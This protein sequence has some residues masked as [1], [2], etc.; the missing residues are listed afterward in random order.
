M[1]GS[2]AAAVF[3]GH[4]SGRDV[5][6]NTD[7]NRGILL[8]RKISCQ[9]MSEMID[10]FERAMY[11]A[12]K[13]LLKKKRADLVIDRGNIAGEEQP[14]YFTGHWTT[15]S[16]ANNGEPRFVFSIANTKVLR[17]S[18]GL[19]GGGPRSPDYL[20]FPNE[21]FLEM[22]WDKKQ[23]LID[24]TLGSDWRSL[25][26]AIKPS[27]EDFGVVLPDLRGIL[28]EC[29]HAGAFL[30]I[31]L[32]QA[33][34]KN[35]TGEV[36]RGQPEYLLWCFIAFLRRQ[37]V[38]LLPLPS[39][40]VQFWASVHTRYDNEVIFSEAQNN[41][42]I[43]LWG[44]TEKYEEPNRLRIMRIAQTLFL[45]ADIR[46]TG[47]ISP[48]AF[49]TVM[50]TILGGAGASPTYRARV[51][52]LARSTYDFFAVFWNDSE[53]LVQP[54]TYAGAAFRHNTPR[55]KA[56]INSSKRR[57]DPF[58]FAG[59][60][61]D[62]WH[63]GHPIAGYTPKDVVRAWAAVL[64]DTFPHLKV[65]DPTRFRAAGVHWLAYI[66]SLE[67]PPTQIEDLVRSRHIND[68]VSRSE[69]T[70]RRWLVDK[71]ESPNTRNDVLAAVAQ[72]FD[73][74]LRAHG[75]DLR[76][77]IQFDLDRFLAPQQRGKTPRTPLSPEM[78]LFLKDFN[79]QGD[80]AFSRSLEPMSWTAEKVLHLRH[81]RRV[82][83]PEDGEQKIMWW[84][85]LA[86][87][88]DLMLTI[89]LRG[90]QAR[91]LDTGE[92]DE[93]ITDPHTLE[94]RL[95]LLP[96]A[97]KG[98]QMGVFTSFS[99]GVE[100][101]ERLLGLRI[102]TNKQA[103]ECDG[104]YGI[105]WCPDDLRDSLSML[106]AWQRYYNPLASLVRAERD[107][108]VN[109]LRNEEV[110]ALI[111]LICPLFRDP[112]SE[113]GAL[114]PTYQQ[115]QTYWNLLC[116][117]AED[118]LH[119]TRKTS[120]RLTRDRIRGGESS[121]SGLQERVAL[122]DLHT[123]RVS[124]ITAL[125]ES[126]L[127]PHLVQE[128]VG[129]AAIVMTLYYQ[130][131]HPGQ[132]NRALADA[133]ESRVLSLDRIPEVLDNLAT[134]ESFL[135]NNRAPEDSVG[136]EMLRSA[137]GN[138]SYQ[139][140][141]HGI[142]P[143]G[144]CRTGGVYQQSM[145]EHAAVP[146]AGACALCR[147]RITGP[148]FL[149]GL[150]VNAN[151]IMAELHGK[152]QEIA[153]LNDEIRARRRDE[154]SVMAF[155]ARYELLHRELEDLWLEWASEHQYVE[156]SAKLLTDYLK[157]QV[158]DGRNLPVLVA[159]GAIAQMSVKSE[160]RHPFHLSQ[161]LAEASAFVPSE[162]HIAAIGMRDVFLNELLVNN[163]IDP[164]LLRLNADTRLH[165][166]NMLGRL[167]SEMVPD[168]DLQAVHDGL[169]PVSTFIGLQEAIRELA[170]AEPVA[171]NSLG[172]TWPRTGAGIL[173]TEE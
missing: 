49:I 83:D 106:L 127:P 22:S 23:S 147:Y 151:K 46:T 77:P 142:C 73:I 110:T 118:H 51:L 140:L 68:L 166:G 32:D 59:V 132:V 7:M 92:G 124:G 101:N 53:E 113:N 138:G 167:L 111:P 131:L 116:V 102:T 164:F 72:M 108:W 99:K 74:H 37:G 136:H 170:M 41:A 54:I 43:R 159:D 71:L 173:E 48:D 162:R 169:L 158:Q 100:T 10:E 128:I 55:V 88:L 94:E 75:I 2:D 90:F 26:A 114:P 66:N 15:G 31:L 156:D 56:A 47:D 144:D 105:P 93:F 30:K 123:L 112:G 129:H 62:E 64:R 82:V 117:A 6:V 65:K 81:Y 78:L 163:S 12:I 141:S 87:L 8:E 19:S 160:H 52:D 1:R 11:G 60:P 38:L 24:R 35:I 76:N 119:A 165:A 57:V 89:P 120:F 28:G 67:N 126:G 161:L 148:M 172:G 29:Q 18:A 97:Q 107:N 155:E 86:V 152:G 133:F 157:Q 134:Y 154:K 96:T 149:A 109:Q 104:R 150:V 91:W 168:A 5:L 42:L 4:G 16:A 36:R 9:R 25:K 95:N 50:E 153:R 146:R 33:R 14:F 39:Y 84:P 63:S 103:V 135:L 125:I 121:A 130:K 171:I 85:G 69:G 80:F 45:C 122:F 58:W 70:F 143:G 20:S 61:D 98:R 34:P 44:V 137:I 79:R 145:K 139:V 40:Y 13:M 3:R 27:A 115:L 21:R 17:A